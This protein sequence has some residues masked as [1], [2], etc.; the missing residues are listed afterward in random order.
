MEEKMCN[1]YYKLR[2]YLL[3]MTFKLCLWVWRRRKRWFFVFFWAYR[4]SLP[5]IY[6]PGTVSFR[7]SDK[8]GAFY[9]SFG[10]PPPIPLCWCWLDFIFLYSPNLRSPISDLQSRQHS[11]RYPWQVVESELSGFLTISTPSSSPGF[12][13][14]SVLTALYFGAF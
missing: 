6:P 8:N 14:N 11:R 9:T 1:F 13:P 12:P 2:A 4:K 5:C 10:K 7:L 3:M